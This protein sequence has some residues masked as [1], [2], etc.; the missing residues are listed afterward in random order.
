MTEERLLP[1]PAAGSTGQPSPWS[2]WSLW[3]AAV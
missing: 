1:E 2:L 3:A